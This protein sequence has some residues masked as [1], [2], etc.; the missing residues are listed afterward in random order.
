MKISKRAWTGQYSYDVCLTGNFV[1]NSV[2]RGRPVSGVPSYSY[3]ISI[4]YYNSNS[5]NK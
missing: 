2:R 3:D 5:D 4:C 1:E